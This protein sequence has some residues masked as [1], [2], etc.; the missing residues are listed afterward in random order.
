MPVLW[1]RTGFNADLDLGAKTMQI[2]ADPDPAQTLKSQNFEFFT[3]NIHFKKVK[4][5]KKILNCFIE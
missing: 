5:K 3:W 4:G 1:I 2:Q